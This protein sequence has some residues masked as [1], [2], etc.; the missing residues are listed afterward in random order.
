MTAT[1]ARTSGFAVIIFFFMAFVQSSKNCILWNSVIHQ[2]PTKSIFWGC[3]PNH[4]RWIGIRNIL[5]MVCQQ[6]QNKG[7]VKTRTHPDLSADLDLLVKHDQVSLFRDYLH[8]ISSYP[9]N[10]VI[11]LRRFR[12]DGYFDGNNSLVRNSNCSSQWELDFTVSLTMCVFLTDDSAQGKWFDSKWVSNQRADWP[13]LHSETCIRRHTCNTFGENTASEESGHLRDNFSCVISFVIQGA[14]FCCT[15]TYWNIATW[16][17]PFKSWQFKP[18]SRVTFKKTLNCNILPVG[19][20]TFIHE[21]QRR[22]R[23]YKAVARLLH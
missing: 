10:Y 11:K 14:S 12:G 9:L 7:V 13:F 8:T 20:A 19:L 22:T 17:L 1:I 3:L 5:P 6:P 23:L 4:K 15:C 21:G 16:Y 18:F 2:G